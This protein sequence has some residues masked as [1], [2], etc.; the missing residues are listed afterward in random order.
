[1]KQNYAELSGEELTAEHKRLHKK[2]MPANIVVFI[3][4]VVALVTLLIGPVLDMRMRIT[5][6]FVSDVYEQAMEESIR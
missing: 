6:E 1:M 4:S 3:L 5:Q 2:L